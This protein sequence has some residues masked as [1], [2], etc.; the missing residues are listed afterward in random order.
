MLKR[1]VISE[2]A[3]CATSRVEVYNIS[4]SNKLVQPEEVSVETYQ[5]PWL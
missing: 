4:G 5:M 2:I 1:L 3:V